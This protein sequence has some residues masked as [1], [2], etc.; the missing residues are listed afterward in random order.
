ME[1]PDKSPAAQEQAKLASKQ[2]QKK[3]D[4]VQPFACAQSL[5]HLLGYVSKH[6]YMQNF[7]HTHRKRE[8]ERER[9]RHR[10]CDMH[11]AFFKS[12]CVGHKTVKERESSAASPLSIGV[13]ADTCLV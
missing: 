8:R 1:L 4:K 7:T 10:A 5:C 11:Y 13:P 9:E 12:R 6:A 3:E 2:S